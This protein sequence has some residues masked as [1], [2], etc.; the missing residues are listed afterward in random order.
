MGQLDEQDIRVLSHYAEKGNRVLYWNYL[1]QRPGNDGYGLLALDVVRNDNM[2]G[3]V[4]NSY[5]QVQARTVSGRSLTEREWEM[6]G[7]DLIQRDLAYRQVMMAKDRPDQ[8]LNLPVE[9]VQKAHDEAFQ[10][11]EV[12]VDAWTPRQLLEAA[13]RRGGEA[14][15][16]GVWRNMLNSNV[17]G[18]ERF[19]KTLA[20]TAY[21]YNDGPLHAFAY[22]SDL[23]RAS[24]AAS[25]S[26]ALTNPNVI[27]DK[28]RH[29][30]YDMDSGHWHLTSSA[31]SVRERDPTRIE[32]L[33][34]IR[35]VRMER[36]EKATQ[37]H[38][39]DPHRTIMKSPFTLADV[40]PTI[41]PGGPAFAG[42]P[43]TRSRGEAGSVDD[44]F[45]RLTDA[46]MA[47]DDAGMRLVTREYMATDEARQWLQE[48]RDHLQAERLA[49][50]QALEAQQA[51]LLQ[52]APVERGHVMSL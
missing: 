8:A 4:A 27:G 52:A 39:G 11:A 50:Q 23:G 46:A 25:T 36:Q 32:S 26:L 24:A 45:E 37:F 42:T 33:N 12:T 21:F 31:A 9:F 40:Q 14:E 15:A 1:A 5:A 6:F 35:A 29:Y 38:P 30:R 44:L 41:E 51:A 49:A 16:Q 28:F 2:P 13:R 22:V 3:A 20:D 34:E 43:P 19:V 47:K 17:L 7:Q 48:G 10:K 18:A